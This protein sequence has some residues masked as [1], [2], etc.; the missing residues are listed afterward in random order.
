MSATARELVLTILLYNENKAIIIMLDELLIAY[1]IVTFIVTLVL[2]FQQVSNKEKT[3]L[4]SSLAIGLM[5]TQAI[6]SVAVFGGDP[7]FP[8][9]AFLLGAT[10]LCH[11]A[12][13]HWNSDFSGE[14]CA[15]AF[16]QLK[17][18][19]NHE[20]WVVGSVVAGLISVFHV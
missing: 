16:F 7:L 20:T 10:I 6:V 5:I 17:D 8:L 11:H 2:G 1:Y 13:I 18:V 12:V 14:T 9:T 19:S 15:C 4:F 3:G